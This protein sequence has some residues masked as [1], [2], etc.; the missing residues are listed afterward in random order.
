MLELLANEAPL[1]KV[2]DLVRDARQG[3]ASV[4]V[5]DELASARAL[6]QE[7]HEMFG[8][9]RRREAGL[10]ALIDIARELISPDDL[11][12]LLSVIPRR[13]RLLLG[14][15]SAYLTVYDPS[16]PHGRLRTSGGLVLP[17]AD[18]PAD[19][20][21][22]PMWTPDHT[23]DDASWLPPELARVMTAD[24]VH[25]LVAVPIQG[26]ERA[27]GTLYV[28][29]RDIRYFTPDEV[30]LVTSLAALVEVAVEQAH[31]FERDAAAIAHLHQRLEQVTDTVTA[32]DAVQRDQSELTDRVLGGAD[33]ATLA[34]AA[35]D[36]L[37]GTLV[38]LDPAE[39]VIAATGPV[40]ALADLDVREGLLDAHTDGAPRRLDEHT[41]ITP[42][43][44]NNGDHGGLVLHR[45]LPLDDAAVRLLRAVA[46]SIAVVRLVECS[47]VAAEGHVRDELLD[48]LLIPRQR[49]P[50]SLTQRARR[51]AIDL[52]MPHVVVIARPEGGSPGRAMVWAS[53]YALRTGGLAKP[54]EGSVVML[55]PGEDATAIG[56]T[57][58]AE[59][60]PRLGHPVSVGAAGPAN[61][62]A[63]I[64]RVHREAARCLEVLTLLDTPGRVASPRELGFLG[65]LLS[66]DHD[67]DGFVDATLRPVIEYDRTHYT[68][69]TRTLEAYFESGGSPTYAAESLY[70]HPNTVSRRLARITALLGQDWQAPARAVELQLALK[71]HRTRKTLLGDD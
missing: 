13:A 43:T 55:L 28:A 65:V 38:V 34:T 45:D 69:L 58:A 4:E 22:G 64:P 21:P 42:I 23:A 54:H 70:V 68:E 5:L 48:D 12:A 16:L 19:Q 61:D 15:D 25:A 26:R 49:S 47:T 9:R 7:V 31:R 37:R 56:R 11:D 40:D 27:F 50:R 33:L 3:G 30:S 51:L 24:G 29:D 66:D 10:T 39:R 32:L 41:W 35:A 1:C 52:S 14:A 67:V 53:S 59:L 36:A 44:I 6:A 63:E 57:V 18:P 60:S 46:Q 2:D 17:L 20:Q 71:L 8:R 62:L